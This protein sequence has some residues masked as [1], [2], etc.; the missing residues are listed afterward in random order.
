MLNR[1]STSLFSCY[2]LVL[3]GQISGMQYD[4]I[5]YQIPYPLLPIS[6]PQHTRRVFVFSFGSGKEK[7]R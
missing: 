1:S 4:M 5:G 2:T 3:P 6:P 7:R